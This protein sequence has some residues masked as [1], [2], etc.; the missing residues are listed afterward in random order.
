MNFASRIY[1]DKDVSLN[2]KFTA[3]AEHDYW[4]RSQNLN[5]N[6]GRSAAEAINKF[7][8]NATENHITDLVSEDSVTNSVILLIN[9]LYFNGKWQ[10][11]FNKTS[12]KPFQSS[13]GKT[14]KTFMEHTRNFYY[15]NSAKLGA[16]I[17]RLPYA[18][19]KFSMFIILPK[20]GKSLDSVIESFDHK[21]LSDE[22][23]NLEE[24]EVHVA[25]PRFRFDSSNNLN[26]A[27]Q[28]V[29]GSF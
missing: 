5:F 16:K 18:G 21:V 27:I 20:E 13:S 26:Q 11:A 28:A 29:S 22:I 4:A 25:L 9:A 24:L 7:V 12:T 15:F 2:Q 23:K 19:D 8:R 3:T 6:D 17:L 14:Q 10:Y 1:V